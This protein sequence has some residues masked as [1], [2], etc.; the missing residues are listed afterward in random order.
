MSEKLSKRKKDRLLAVI[1]QY[2]VEKS[3][4]PEALFRRERLGFSIYCTHQDPPAEY[5]PRKV[6][7]SQGGYLYRRLGRIF[8]AHCRWIQRHDPQDIIGVKLRTDVTPIIAEGYGDEKAQRRR[9]EVQN[10]PEDTGWAT[11]KIEWLWR[12]A[13]PSEPLPEIVL[14]EKIGLG[15]W[16]E[17]VDIGD[18][19]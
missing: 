6:A 10:R 12:K 16:D 4:D 9:L 14:D 2:N 15:S 7:F 11:Q 13:L 19:L 18:Y 5:S 3:Q 17:Y 1:E 8:V